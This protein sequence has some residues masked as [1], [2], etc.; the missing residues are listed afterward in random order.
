MKKKARLRALSLLL[1]LSMLLSLLPLP[2]FAEDDVLT[3]DPSVPAAEDTIPAEE[4]ALPEDSSEPAQGDTAPVPEDNTLKDVSEV[5]F[6]GLSPDGTVIFS[7]PDTFSLS[8]ISPVPNTP[9]ILT[10]SEEHFTVY[11]AGN[12][13]STSSASS[14][15]G[16]FS[17]PGVLSFDINYSVTEYDSLTVKDDSTGSNIIAAGGND[18]AGDSAGWKTIQY[19]FLEDGEHSVAWSLYLMLAEFEYNTGLAKIRNITFTPTITV[20]QYSFN[21]TYDKIK[22][23]FN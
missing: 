3:E 7:T 2:A 4:E 22:T 8:G 6:E 16:T 11:K 23:D 9:W 10:D 14:I 19:S 15:V 5:L 21:I 13:G 18:K 12:T 17:G 20:D 1:T